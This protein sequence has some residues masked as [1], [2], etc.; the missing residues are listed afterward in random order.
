MNDI[1]FFDLEVNEVTKKIEEVGIKYNGID[2]RE[3][4]PQKLI[5]Y[6]GKSNYICGHNII[7]HDLKFLKPYLKDKSILREKKIIDTLLFS[8]LLYPEKPYHKLVKDYRLVGTHTND[9]IADCEL[10]KILL[11]DLINVYNNLSKEL[12]SIYFG[13][14]S[15]NDDYS[16][17]FKYLNSGVSTASLNRNVLL[18]LIIKVLDSRICTNA[19]SL[20]FLNQY[21]IELAYS[22]ALLLTKK[23]DSLPPSWSE[24]QY[25]RSIEIIRKLTVENCDDQDCSY[26]AEVLDPKKALKRFFGFDNFQRFED[27]QE[28]PLQYQAVS[29]AL[30]RESLIAI[31]PTGGGKSL[32]FQLP[33]LLQGEKTKSLTV[34][35]SPLQ[36]LMKDQVDVLKKRHDVLK[37]EFISG[38]QNPLQ[39]R[40]AYNRIM[41]GD[42]NI[43]YLAPESLRSRTIS[44]ILL[45]RHIERFVIDEAHCLSSWGHDFRVDYLYL[46]RFIKKI[47]KRKNYTKKIPISCFT[48]TAKPQVIEDIIAYFKDRLG[49]ELQEFKTKSKRVNLNYYVHET[50]EEYQKKNKLVDLIESVEGPHIIYVSRVRKTIDLTNVL[51]KQGIKTKAFHGKLEPREKIKI[52]EEFMNGDLDAIVATSAFGMGVDKDDV[53]SVVHYDIPDSLENYFQESGRAARRKDL[54]ANC[55]VLFDENDLNSHFQLLNS[56]RL[57]LKEINQ[58]WRA[59]KSYKKQRFCKSAREIAKQAGLDT[60]IRELEIRVK[61]ALSSLEESGYIIRDENATRIFAKSV[62]VENFEQGRQIIEKNRERFPKQEQEFAIRILQNIISRDITEV[63]QISD[64]LG[65]PYYTVSRILG[66]LKEVEIIGDTIEIG[67]RVPLIRGK[68]N[69]R[70]ILEKMSGI[71]RFM[72]S[73][74]WQDTV[75]RK[76]KISLRE[77]NQEMIDNN[78]EPADSERFREIIR[79]WELKRLISKERID[80]ARELYKIEFKVNPEIIKE[81]IDQR[82]E[83]SSRILLRLVEMAYLEKDGQIPLVKFLIKDLKKE[84]EEDLFGVQSNDLV[85]YEEALLYLHNIGAVELERG[86][87]VLY[88]PMNIERIVQDP[89]KQ[90]TKEDYNDLERFYRSKT[91]QI[92]IIG[93]YARLR[94]ESHIKAMKFVDDYFQMSNQEFLNKYFGKRKLKIRKTI[95]ERKFKEVYLDLSTEQ[96]EVVVDSEHNNILVAAG[97]G[98]GKTKLLVHKVASILLTEDVKPEQFL[99][100]TFSRPAADEF[101]YRLKGLIGNVTYYINIFTYHSYAFHLLDRIGNLQKSESIV[102][103]A[104]LALESDEIPL[105]KVANKKVI[106]IDEYQDINKEQYDFIMELARIAEDVRIIVVGDDDQN[107]YEFAGSSARYMFDFIADRK[108]TQY[109]LTKNFRSAINLV[110]YTNLYLK[111]IQ[112]ERIKQNVSLIADR[113]DYGRID[114][115]KYSST[116][117]IVPFVKAIKDYNLSGS[118]GILTSTNEEALIVDNLLEQ[119]GLPSQLIQSYSNFRLGNLVEIHRFTKLV[120]RS[121]KGENGYVPWDKWNESKSILKGEFERSIHLP[122]VLRIIEHF[123]NSNKHI[124]RTDWLAF[125]REIKLED[126]IY[127]GDETMTVS[128]MHKTKGKEYDNVFILHM[129]REVLNDKDKRVLYVALT[130]ARNNLSI[131]TNSNNFDSLATEGL[132]RKD[133]LNTYPEPSK[134]VLQTDMHDLFLDKFYDEEVYKELQ[135]IQSG[136]QIKIKNVERKDITTSN[137]RKIGVLSKDGL[138]KIMHFLD[139]DYTLDEVIAGYKV[140]WKG[141]NFDRETEVLLPK[142]YLTKGDAKT[143]ILE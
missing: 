96:H 130:R 121:V 67:L 88:N 115:V 36:S 18:R 132:N 16:G 34:V 123:D 69:A 15:Q 33:A 61:T 83:L 13:L 62:L 54:E 45:S 113:K 44:R 106:V 108:A 31:F 109:F 103:E 29:S 126:F 105:E 120:L 122:L 95:T 37:A 100:L 104:T 70:N 57:N 71:E 42:V 80:S 28:I 112:G 134:I 52:Q 24:Y 55:H 72:I 40:D 97:P 7:H 75:S 142:V 127:P 81:K 6:I 118:T 136:D 38:L 19:L 125:I 74:L 143:Q 141:K 119:L 89:K 79:F 10:V 107:I 60:E 43:L 25:P 63:D 102:K 133:D 84:V 82:L 87:I 140:I 12:Q 117:G 23:P 32:A 3:A 76:I 73:L 93:E 39:R 99:M 66:H 129:N 139:K 131:H 53:K 77:I 64:V 48:A 4:R 78:L 114:L 9:P 46:A 86:L 124:F 1:L 90:F 58:I 14:L 27:D 92:H 11:H 85:E 51:G 17:F 30:K 2:F 91:E 98:S 47:L 5:D 101:K 68:K 20:N 56:T 65:I 22:I 35:I 59:L 135:A 21:P 137:H 41:D 8:P 50:T 26:C 94:L 49:I 116:Q 110:D 111:N 138:K 128:T